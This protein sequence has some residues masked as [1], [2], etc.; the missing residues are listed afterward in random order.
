MRGGWWTSSTLSALWAGQRERSG[1]KVAAAVFLSSVR[2]LPW[3]SCTR[4]LSYITIG[5]NCV[6]W[7]FLLLWAG[8]L[9]L[10]KCVCG[11]PDFQCDDICNGHMKPDRLLEEVD[12]RGERAQ[13]L[14]TAMKVG[15][16]GFGV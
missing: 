8:C 2:E 12:G 16:Q 9:C 11:S 7:A 4:T 14:A 6:T 1:A 3:K 13:V 10:P 15:S 5:Q